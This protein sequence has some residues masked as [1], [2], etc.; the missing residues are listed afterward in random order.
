MGILKVMRST[1]K[2]TGILVDTLLSKT[3]YVMLYVGRDRSLQCSRSS[4]KSSTTSSIQ[5]CRQHAPSGSTEVTESNRA[6]AQLHSSSNVV[7]E[8]SRSDSVSDE[9]DSIYDDIDDVTDPK[10]YL[11]LMSS[12]G[13]RNSNPASTMYVMMMS[14]GRLESCKTPD[15][16]HAARNGGYCVAC[17]KKKTA[18]SEL[19]AIGCATEADDVEMVSST[20]LQC[21]EP[22][23]E[24]S[25][26]ELEA[27]SLLESCK[28]TD[29]D[30]AS[31]ELQQSVDCSNSHAAAAVH[32]LLQHATAAD[33]TQPWSASGTKYVDTGVCR[34]PYC[35]NAGLTE[36]RGLCRACYRT[37]LAFNYSQRYGTLLDDVDAG[38]D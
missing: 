14:R 33:F 36:L 37:L 30:A 18:G 15:C 25:T 21:V 6:P 1:V 20:A 11:L 28:V 19:P 38:L 4:L 35:S 26:D 9:A 17:Q 23:S 13:I 24:Q 2:V 8:F 29:V 3:I 16:Y 22:G 32:T 31:A 27:S 34:G 10:T 7:A 5:F 12:T